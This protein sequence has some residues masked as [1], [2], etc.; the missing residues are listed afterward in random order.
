MRRAPTLRTRNTLFW[1]L[2]PTPLGPALLAATSR[3]LC[4]LSFVD[5]NAPEKTLAGLAHRWPKARLVERPTATAAFARELARRLRG[6]PGRPRSLLFQGT[7]FQRKVWEALLRIPPG[8]VATYREVAASVRTP[9]A[10]RAVGQAV[11]ANP[12]AV[13]IPCHRVIRS[14]GG[15]GGYRW[16]SWRK[17]ALLGWERARIRPAHRPSRHGTRPELDHLV[18]VLH[19]DRL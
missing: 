5:G 12:I 7:Q 15:L 4:A 13:L 17:R 1:S 19:L 14:D 11:G 6:K 8:D 2:H 10:S 18:P 3:G 9:S 16:G